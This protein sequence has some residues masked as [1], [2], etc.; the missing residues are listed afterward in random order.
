MEDALKEREEAEVTPE[1]REPTPD[2]KKVSIV[3]VLDYTKFMSPIIDAIQLAIQPALQ[4]LTKQCP[5][6]VFKVGFIAY[7]NINRGAKYPIRNELG[8]V[9]GEEEKEEFLL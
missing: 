3:L 1:P 2:P 6:Y 8:E 5:N 7:R 9:E 4:T